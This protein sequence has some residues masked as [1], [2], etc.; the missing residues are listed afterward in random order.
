MTVF[1]RWEAKL[2]GPRRLEGN[3]LTRNSK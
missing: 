3:P 1:L 2:R